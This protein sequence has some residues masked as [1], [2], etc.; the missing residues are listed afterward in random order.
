MNQFDSVKL[1]DVL[2]HIKKPKFVLGTTYSLSLAFFESTVF[3]CFSRDELQACLLLCDIKGYRNALIEAPA[4]Q[5]A[6]QDYMVVPAPTSGS[7]HP[8]V[9][10][11]MS[12]EEVCLL[13]GSGN[14]TQ[15]GF[16]TN[17]E[18]FDVV[19]FSRSDPAPAE[20][21]SSISAFV[22]G[23]HE[24]WSPSDRKHLLCTKTLFRLGEHLSK[25][26]AGQASAPSS[27]R[28]LHT[29]SGPLVDQLPPADDTQSLHIAAPF[30]GNCTRGLDI[31]TK[32]Y[33]SADLHVYP[34][35]HNGT[36]TDLDLRAVS[37]SRTEKGT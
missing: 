34:A 3:P 13:V 28:F 37:Q 35:V 33:P 21:L 12:D 1:S 5:G 10:L 14:L 8:K 32:R 9:W 2:K 17:A 23:L 19:T 24:L 22:Q 4:L 36:E 11:V 30:F 6:A 31:L 16:M 29:F 26:P 7:F 20:L 27:V 15:S 25:F 18:L